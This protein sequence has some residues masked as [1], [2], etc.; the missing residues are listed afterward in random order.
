MASPR[1]RVHDLIESTLVTFI[2]SVADPF[3]SSPDCEGCG[4]VVVQVADVSAPLAA[5][6]HFHSLCQSGH[7]ECADPGCAA[8]LCAREGCVCRYDVDGE[9]CDG[10]IGDT[11]ADPQDCEPPATCQAGSCD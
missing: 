2:L 8:R 7:C 5:A 6:C 11:V 9:G 3:A 4:R 10:N 1:A